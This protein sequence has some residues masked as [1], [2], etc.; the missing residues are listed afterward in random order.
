VKAAVQSGDAGKVK[1]AMT[2]YV[3]QT[4]AMVDS[5]PAGA[6]AAVKAAYQD[7]LTAVTNT[8]NGT[9]TKAQ[10]AALA[11]ADPIISKYYTSICT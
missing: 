4:K 11:A 3:P 7:V 6:S 9:I 1:M 5:L 2:A 8:G 10:S